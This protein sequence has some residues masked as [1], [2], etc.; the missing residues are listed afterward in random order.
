VI[1]PEGTYK[2]RRK[3]HDFMVSPKKG[4]EYISIVFRISPD[5]PHAGDLVERQAWLTDA[6][7]DRTLADLKL[8]G[9][10][11]VDI[12]EL[13]PLDNEVDIVIKHD[14]DDN[15]RPT[16]RVA[17]INEVGAVFGGRLMEK[18]QL[19]K[20]AERVKSRQSGGGGGGIPKAGG[21][22]DIPF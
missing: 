20:L 10:D 18:G 17:F 22:K 3:R 15:D 8:L 9:W 1:I 4:T 12:E 21:G 11:G 2:A 13:G 16:A 6:A 7:M 19:R 14:Y 5:Q